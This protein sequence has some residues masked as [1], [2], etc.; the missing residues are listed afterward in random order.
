ML[1]AL[2]G[3]GR[4]LAALVEGMEEFPQSLI[5]VR[6]RR[7]PDLAGLPDVQAAVAVAEAALGRNGRIDL[8]YSGTEM[9]ARVMVE[10]RDR[11]TVDSCAML[12]A[13]A[14]RRRI[15]EKTT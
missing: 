10:A 14:V 6:V 3:S 9:L 2:V 12:V 11:A 15:G 13:E 1:E 8:R 4:T 5:N 7:K